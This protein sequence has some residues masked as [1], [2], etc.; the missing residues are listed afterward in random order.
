MENHNVPISVSIRKDSNG[1][2]Y[3]VAEAFD[4]HGNRRRL[5][6]RPTGRFYLQDYPRGGAER[7]VADALN[8]EISG[9]SSIRSED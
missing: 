8:A 9:V 3:A 1:N 7:A 4:W 2:R 5:G 6:H